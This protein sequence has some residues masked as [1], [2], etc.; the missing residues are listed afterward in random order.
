VCIGER[1]T[2]SFTMSNHTDS[3]VRFLWPDN[4][5]LKFSPRVGHLHAGRS[6]DMTVTLSVDKAL[7]WLE[8]EVKCHVVRVVYDRP[9]ADVTD[10]DDRLKTVKWIPASAVDTY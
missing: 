10:W 6:K 7:T 5:R 1:R 3:A 2:L 4:S 9:S 8:H